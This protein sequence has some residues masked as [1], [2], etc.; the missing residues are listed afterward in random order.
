MRLNLSQSHD[1]SEYNI[2]MEKH[3]IWQKKQRQKHLWSGKKLLPQP[4]LSGTISGPIIPAEYS[5]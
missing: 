4:C 3:K 1:R 2:E 5:K